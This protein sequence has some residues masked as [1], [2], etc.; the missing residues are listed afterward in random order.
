MNDSHG[1]RR[2]KRVEKRRE[3]TEENCENMQRL[4]ALWCIYEYILLDPGL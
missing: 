3:G 2:N 1:I 4:V